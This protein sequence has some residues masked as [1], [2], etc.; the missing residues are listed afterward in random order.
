MELRP[1]QGTTTL[2]ITL[3]PDG[4]L[5]VD[6]PVE[7]LLL[8]YGLLG[9]AKDAIREHNAKNGKGRIEIASALKVG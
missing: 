3:Y 2:K 9:L 6:G 7:N 5:G 8:C 1:P 4:R